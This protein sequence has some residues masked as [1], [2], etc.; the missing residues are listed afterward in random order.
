MSIVFAYLI[1]IWYSR[2][3]NISSRDERSLSA[4]D[5]FP[6]MRELRMIRKYT[7]NDKECLDLICHKL[8][9]MVCPKC[10]RKLY[11]V[12]TRPKSYMCGSS[13]F[14][15]SYSPLAHTVFRK[16]TI[17]LSAWFEAIYLVYV[18]DGKVPAAEIGRA[19]GLIQP[20]QRLEADKTGYKTAW[21]IKHVIC[22][23]L[24]LRQPFGKGWSYK[25]SSVKNGR[26]S[27][28]DYKRKHNL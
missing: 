19:A 22:A 8:T 1:D 17:P 4:I 28:E 14:G 10:G 18:S 9:N 21:R 2:L 24:G 16:T 11:W 3:M 26:Y 13:G 15:H 12:S 20:L 27:Q 23:Y 6:T 5:Y 7:M 25:Y